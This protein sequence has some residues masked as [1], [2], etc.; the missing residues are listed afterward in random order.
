MKYQMNIQEAG[1]IPKIPLIMCMKFQIFID[2]RI[3]S[4]LYVGFDAS[5]KQN[6]NVIHIWTCSGGLLKGE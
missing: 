2:H 4:Y 5:Q 3:K 6:L 1:V